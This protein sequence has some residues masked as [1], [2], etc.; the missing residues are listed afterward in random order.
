M[1]GGRAGVIVPSG[2]LF[3]STKAASSLRELLMTECDLQAV[4][5][6]PS[7][8]FKPYSGVGTAALVLQKGRPTE[9][10]W[11]YDLTADGFSLDDKRTPID[12]NDIPDVLAKWPNREEGPN[13]Y[14]VPV[15]MI[16]EN[17]WSLAAGRYKPFTSKVTNHDRPNEILT[18]V[19]KLESKII[20]RGRALLLQ[21][22]GRK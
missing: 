4:I 11:F 16:K 2:V 15:E 10:V 1:P 7:G 12:S 3:G 19:L 8:I 22:S 20:E 5:S 14:R 13:S 9:T 21:I 6:F 18:E 17:D